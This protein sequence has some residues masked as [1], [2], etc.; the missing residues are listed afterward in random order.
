MVITLWFI[1]SE[2]N[3]IRE[4]GKQRPASS[5][6]RSIEMYVH[7]NAQLSSNVPNDKGP[8]KKKWCKPPENVLK[9]N[10]DGS[11]K[12][13]EMN[14]SWGFL[15]RDSDGDLV[16]TG[17]GK[18]D[19]LW[20]ALHSELIACLQGL[21]IAADLGIG[22][23]IL[24]TDAQEVVSA[25]NSS[26]YDDSVL[27]CLVEELKFQAS[28]NFVSF[29]CVHVSRTCNEAAH[30]LACLGYLCTEG[31]EIITDTIPDDIAVIVANYS[32]SR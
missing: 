8:S 6:V 27:G 1:W 16:K 21:Q 15:I 23:L 18:V 17:R 19:N 13:N 25:M 5:I 28:I 20:S 29:A 11:F 32:V 26:A 10:I 9:V 12:P 2:R 31:E 14:G 7:E 4:E 30:E 3:I 22:Q 24:E